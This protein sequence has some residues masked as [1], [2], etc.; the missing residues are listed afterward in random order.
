MKVKIKDLKNWEKNP[1]EIDKE[2]FEA[3]KKY[4]KKYGLLSPLIV[5]GRDKKTVLGGNMRL[6]ALKELG[7]EEV[8]IKYITPKDD[9][10]AVEIALLDNAQFGKY[11]REEIEKL[12]DNYDIGNDIDIAI[13]GNIV[14]ISELS[15]LTAEIE[16]IEEE[17]NIEIKN[18]EY[19]VVSEYGDIWELGNSR[20][21][22]GDCTVVEDLDLLMGGVKAEMV[23]ADPPYGMKKEAD[24]VI[25]DNLNLKKL[26]EFNKEWV[27]LSLDLLKDNGSWYCWGRDEPLMDI[28]SNILKPY[29]EENKITFR[30]LLTWYKG[31]GQGQNSSVTRMY[32]IADE[33]CLFIMKGVQGFNNNSDNY[34]DGWEPIRQYLLKSRLEMGWDVPTMKNIAGHSDKSRDHWTSKSQWLLPT[35]EVYKRFQEEVRKREKKDKRKYNAFKKEYE[36]IKKEYEEI[37]KEYYSSR[38]YFDN[39]HDNFNNVWIFERHLRDG[40]EGGHPTP[41]PIPLVTRAVK[42]SCPVGGVILDPFIG[43]GTTLIVAEKNNRICY[44]MELNNHYVDVIVYRYYNM[45]GGDNIRLNRGGKYIKWDEVKERLLSRFI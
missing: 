19:N 43:S 34:Y 45:F 18:H 15:N 2:K 20:V 11:I 23:F 38:A 29:I 6:K 4:I 25:N 22:C 30:N 41:K 10:E 9:S 7:V 21:M 28:Y 12:L 17:I 1:R 3:L 5:D 8:E 24:G 13:N 26:L 32:A 14:D 16:D 31:N 33:K 35:E 44:G 27:P 40:T 39:T 37:K 36:E 42:T